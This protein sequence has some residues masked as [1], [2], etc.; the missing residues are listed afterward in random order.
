MMKYRTCYGRGRAN[1]T[2]MSRF[3]CLVVGFGDKIRLD[4]HHVDYRDECP[5]AQASFKAPHSILRSL[6]A[7]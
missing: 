2:P 7:A 6:N 5:A 4:A 1:T 3:F